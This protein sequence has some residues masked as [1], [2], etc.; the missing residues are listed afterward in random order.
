MYFTK[1]GSRDAIS[2]SRTI[3]CAVKVTVE[4]ET[5]AESET[6]ARGVGIVCVVGLVGVE[7]D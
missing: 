2:E 7:G 5:T 6:E 4:T 3:R 1:S